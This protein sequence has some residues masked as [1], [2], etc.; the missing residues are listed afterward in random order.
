MRIGFR[1]ITEKKLLPFWCVILL[2]ILALGL[3]L[4]AFSLFYFIL[5]KAGS[6]P[7][8][9]I[10]DVSQ[11][12]TPTRA[13]TEDGSTPGSIPVSAPASA[14]PPGDFSATF[15]K[16][17]TSQGAE[18]S[19]QTDNVRIAVRKVQKHEVVYFVADVWVRNISYLR[20]AFAKKQYGQGIH[21]DF[22]GIA[23]D[24]GAIA[25]IS[26]DY[27]GARSKGVVIHNGQLYRNSAL[28]DVCVIY[29]N[30]VMETFTYDAF[31]LD[32]AVAKKAY[33]AW[34]FGPQLL[35]D[36]QPME[37]FNSTVNVANPRCAIGYYEPG[38]YCFVTV[39]G[40]QAGY[41]N[42][43]TLM[44]LS[45]LF[46]DLG[47]KTA[48]NLDGGQTAMMSFKGELVNQP[49]KGGRQS[50]DIIYIAE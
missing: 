21:Q 12:A 47:C 15:P 30:G 7:V 23:N 1:G 16:E 28:D 22:L 10:V 46:Y 48:Y 36:G 34:S 45:R 39:D 24:N 18:L 40:R 31:N 8:L 37:K 38:H 29:Q 9:H 6:G 35:Q 13:A 19:Y 3:A 4:G 11:E 27:Y 2:D 5:P 20:T 14:Y 44:E 17:D 25:A 43:M 33:Q 26:G 42:G 50:S 32:A 49:Y 41:S